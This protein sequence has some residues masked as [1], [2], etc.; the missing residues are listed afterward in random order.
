MI[1]NIIY[2]ICQELMKNSYFYKNIIDNIES[3]T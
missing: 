2:Y 3:R 1:I